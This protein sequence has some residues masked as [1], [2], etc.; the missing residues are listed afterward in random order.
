M[1]CKKCRRET[2]KE[3]CEMCGAETEREIPLEVYWCGDCKVPIIKY[4]NDIDRDICPSCGG[5]TSY[6]C[7][8]LRP[9]FPEERLLFEIIQGKP[10]AYIEKSV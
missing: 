5:H 7:A 1:W 9:V 3:K 4:A 2:I 6:L 8:D 10:L